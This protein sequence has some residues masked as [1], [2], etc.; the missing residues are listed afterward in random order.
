VKSDDLRGRDTQTAY[1]LGGFLAVFALPVLA[2]ALVAELPIDRWLAL[3]SGLT[4]LAV[5]FVFLAWGRR[6]QRAQSG[7]AK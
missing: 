3:F 7:E 1:L 2:G 4:L 5:A 6:R